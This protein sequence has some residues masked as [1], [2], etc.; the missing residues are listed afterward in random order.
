MLQSGDGVGGASGW[1]G[2]LVA[3]LKL[4][5]PRKALRRVVGV[6]PPY[7]PPF[8]R[9]R[10]VL[11]YHAERPAA[12]EKRAANGVGRALARVVTSM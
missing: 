12:E 4:A 2:P 7:G 6:E 10:V 9:V 8:L 3:L 11:Q 1:R 5:M